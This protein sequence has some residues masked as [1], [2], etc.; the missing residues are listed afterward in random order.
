M[1]PFDIKYVKKPIG[2]LK[3]PIDVGWECGD[4]INMCFWL[5]ISAEMYRIFG[6]YVNPNEMKQFIIKKIT[7]RYKTYV[8]IHRY[9]TRKIWRKRC[10]LNM[11]YDRMA[12]TEMFYYIAVKYGLIITFHNFEKFRRHRHYQSSFQIRP[13]DNNNIND[14]IHIHYSNFHY[15]IAN[16]KK[17]ITPDLDKWYT[18]I[19]SLTN[20]ES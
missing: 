6:E 19:D 7:R 14:E 4:E 10:N 20:Q 15:S 5:V 17:K 2:L 1:K 11:K 13:I 16:F 8:D 12:E 3:K 9:P 18:F